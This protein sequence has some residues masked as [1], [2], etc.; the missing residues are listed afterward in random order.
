MIRCSLL[1]LRNISELKELDVV[2]GQDSES[3][4]LDDDSTTCQDESPN[5]PAHDLENITAEKIEFIQHSG[6]ITESVL[7][8]RD[9]RLE[10]VT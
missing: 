8:V 2:V 4:L 5:Q 6:I 10:R 3:L 1:I 7:D 9:L